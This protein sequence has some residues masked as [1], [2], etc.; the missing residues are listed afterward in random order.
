MYLVL[1][2]CHIFLKLRIISLKWFYFFPLSSWWCVSHCDFHL[3]GGIPFLG[4]FP[5][6]F[7]QLLPIPFFLLPFFPFF[8][9]S[10]ISLVSSRSCN[11]SSFLIKLGMSWITPT[12]TPNP[13]FETGLWGGWGSRGGRNSALFSE[14]H[15]KDRGLYIW[16]F[17]FM[18]CCQH[19]GSWES[20]HKSVSPALSQR[21]CS[22]YWFCICVF[23]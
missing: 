11:D 6:L 10:S 7:F 4:T 20:V 2:S 13:W 18:C 9:F 23:N 22:L 15:F 16:V 3:L 5:H 21:L 14:K 8:P 19:S 1:W 17:N 12:A